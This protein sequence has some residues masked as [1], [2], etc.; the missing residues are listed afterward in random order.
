MIDISSLFFQIISFFYIV[1]IAVAYFSK[2]KMNTLENRI[3]STLIIVVFITL[4]IDCVSVSLGLVDSTSFI[5]NL[6]G[7]LYLVCIIAWVFIFTY[8]MFVISFNKQKTSVMVELDSKEYVFFKKVFY[9]FLGLFALASII[10]LALPLHVYGDGK[11]MYTYGPCAIVSYSFAALCIVSWIVFMVSN[12]RE[13]RDKK[14]IPAFAFVV[15]AGTAAVIQSTFP[16][17]LLVTAAATFIT[18]LTY[19]TIEN[20]DL[21]MIAQLN[22]AK[23][24]ADKANQAKSDFLSNMSHE[25]RTPLNAIVGFG[26]ALSEEDLPPQAMSE[27]KDIMMASDNLLEIVNG[28]LDISKIESGKLEIINKDYSFKK[29]FDEVV[30]LAKGRLGEKPLEFRVVYDE[31][32]PPVLFGDYSRI[33]E[34]MINLLTNAIKYTHEGYIELKVSSVIKDDI[35]RIIISV[36]DSGIGIKQENINKLFTKFE[37]LGVEEHSTIEGTGLGLAIT[38]KLL[39][40]MNGQIVVQSVYGKGSRFTVA[41][42]QKISVGHKLEDTA[43]L[44][45][46]EL[47]TMDFSSKKVLVVDDNVINLKVAHRLLQEYK[48]QITEVQ[49]GQ[50]AIDLINAGNMYDLILMDDM[51]PKMSGVQTLQKLKTIPGFQMKVVALTANAITGMREKYLADGFDEYL[52]KPISKKELAKIIKKMLGN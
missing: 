14:Y 10:I 45:L 25:I 30:T 27:V 31:S 39:D 43:S 7:K 50:A 12:I 1:L 3:Y 48:V 23:E 52:A 37:R 9:I 11:I 51:M 20:P 32:I 38:K 2:K 35:C 17:Y 15:V 8:Y 6:F 4:I 19:F 13:I 47:E 18:I 40:L 21:K 22:L 46:T 49:S 26:Q 28:I 44:D 33:K 5:T 29:I 42:D 24:Q 16:E 34:I 41:I 36:E